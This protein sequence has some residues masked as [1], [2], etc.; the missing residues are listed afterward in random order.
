M[1]TLETSCC[2]KCAA[3]SCR[4]P[5]KVQKLRTW[6]SP[7]QAMN[8]FSWPISIAA[9]PGC[10]LSIINDWYWKLPTRPTENGK[11]NAAKREHRGHGLKAAATR[12]QTI[13]LERQNKS[14]ERALRTKRAP[15]TLRVDVRT[16]SSSFPPFNPAKRV[17][18]LPM[19]SYGNALHANNF[20]GLSILRISL[21]NPGCPAPLS[22][23]RSGFWVSG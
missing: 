5:L 14:Q 10:I 16:I 18:G 15:V 19:T 8:I 17:L 12:H 20:R 6:E 11:R 3:A 22:I 13:N 2:F 4:S 21:R 23:P 7:A 1:A 9:Y